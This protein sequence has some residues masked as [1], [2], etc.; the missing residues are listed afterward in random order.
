MMSGLRMGLKKSLLIA[1]MLAPTALVFNTTISS[2]YGWHSG[3]EHVFHMMVYCADRSHRY[4]MDDDR[5][6]FLK[7]T[8]VA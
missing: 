7:K 4:F 1:T 2:A 5:R 8:A 6:C 3:T